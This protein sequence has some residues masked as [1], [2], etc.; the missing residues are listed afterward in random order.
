MMRYLYYIKT[1]FFARERW[2]LE[3]PPDTLRGRDGR[4]AGRVDRDSAMESQAEERFALGD[5]SAPD[6]SATTKVC[7]SYQAVFAGKVKSA[8]GYRCAITGIST[9]SFLVA[10]HIVP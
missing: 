10:A 1:R 5:T 6:G 3:F 2:L 4:R 8:Y 9:R 7:G